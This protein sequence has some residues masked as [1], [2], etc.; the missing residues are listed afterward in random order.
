KVLLCLAATVSKT[1]WHFCTG[2]LQPRF[3]RSRSIA[4]ALRMAICQGLKIHCLDEGSQ[5]TTL[6]DGLGGAQKILEINS[7]KHVYSL[8]RR[9]QR[10][11]YV[12]FH[13]G[14]P[15][16]DALQAIDEGTL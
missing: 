15:K 4:V 1:C 5:F 10:R 11:F 13:I 2:T 7:Y 14:C 8:T 3:T 16:N 12:P 6:V 9:S